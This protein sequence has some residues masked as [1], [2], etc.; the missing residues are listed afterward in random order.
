MF[1]GPAEPKF[2]ILGDWLTRKL[3]EMGIGHALPS[4]LHGQPD[5]KTVNYDI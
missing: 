5:F 2:C 3:G 4:E 1:R